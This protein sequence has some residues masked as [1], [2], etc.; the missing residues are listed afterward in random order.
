[1]KIAITADN[2][3]QHAPN[4]PV[5]IRRLLDDVAAQAADVFCVLGDLGEGQQCGADP[6][7]DSLLGTHPKTLFILG[8]H[9]LWGRP[10]EKLPPP[11]SMDRAIT[12]FRSGFLLET[13]WDDSETVNIIQD[14]A[15]IGCMGFPDFAHPRLEGRRDFYDCRSA[16]V[17]HEF[18]WLPNGWLAHT[19]HMMRACAKRLV[20]A[21][22][23]AAKHVVVLTHYPIL[24]GQSLLIDQ[25]GELQVWPYFFNWTMGRMVLGLAKAHPEKFVWCMAGHSHEF[26]R[27]KLTE[28]SPNVFSFGLKT[29][30]QTQDYFVFDT[31]APGKGAAFRSG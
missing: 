14:G 25:P 29:S 27:G 11:E 24:E 23:S 18:I 3:V 5:A 6:L 26:C 30:Y 16:T 9:D 4:A 17:D 15:F 19:D 22:Q 8:N 10:N 13:A 2:H 21:F 12:H 7:Y 1:M 28:E 20:A 31:D